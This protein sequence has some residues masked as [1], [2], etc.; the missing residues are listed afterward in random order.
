LRAGPDAQA[1]VLCRSNAEA[2]KVSRR[3]FELDVR[4]RLQ[5]A[6]TDRAVAPWVAR[7]L[8]TATVKTLGRREFERRLDEVGDQTAPE[9]DEAWRLVRRLAGGRGD[10]LDVG[11]VADRIRSRYVPDELNWTPPAQVV[12]STIHRAKGLE[13]D[14]VVLLDGDEQEADGEG[15]YAE[16]TRVLY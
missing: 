12:V 11:A 5:R 7:S 15:A 14:R 2:L 10:V 6:T 13:F 1:A 16:E 3:L 4:H 9:P 8:G